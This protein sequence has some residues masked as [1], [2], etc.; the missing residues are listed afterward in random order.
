MRFTTKP[1]IKVLRFR[2]RP[3]GHLRHHDFQP[4]AIIIDSLLDDAVVSVASKAWNM[5]SYNSISCD[6]IYIFSQVES[7]Q[8]NC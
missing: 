3:A 7:L 5:A 4:L 8:Y 2:W 6:R 1:G